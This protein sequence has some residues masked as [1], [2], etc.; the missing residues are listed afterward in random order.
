MGRSK[1]IEAF[2]EI[3]IIVGTS[4]PGLF[5]AMIILVVLGLKD[6]T[7]ILTLAFLTSPIMIVSIWQG[8]KNLD[9]SY[10]ELADVFGYGRL[11]KIRHVILP[12]LAGPTLAAVRGGL[13]L[14]WKY[15]VVVEMIGLSSGVGHEVTRSFQMFDLE[16]VVA[17]TM[18]FLALVL[19]IE[20][21]VIR[22][23]ERWIFSWRDRPT[24]RVKLTIVPTIDREDKNHV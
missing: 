21:L 3:F 24:G 8:A 6:S 5:V 12:Q 10:S 18:G 20:Y 23:I 9:P 4:Q 17:W 2:F 7:A 11:A 1:K 13:G 16:S 14:T 22:G 15:I 19:A